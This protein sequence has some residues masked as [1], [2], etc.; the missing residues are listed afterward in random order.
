MAFPFLFLAL[1][2]GAGIAVPSLIPIA[3]T[4]GLLAL[5]FLLIL[6]WLLFFMDRYKLSLVFVLVAVFFLGLSL[7]IHAEGE[8]ETNSLHQLKSDTY[9]DFYGTVYRSPSR[10][11]DSDYL[12]LKIDRAIIQGKIEKLRGKL[13]VTVPH[14]SEFPTYPD[15]IVH[16]KMKVSAKLS[17]STGFQNFAPSPL[18]KN[19]K[20]QNI[21]RRAHTKSPLMVEKLKSG[22][23]LS[24][25]RFIS[26][27]RQRFQKK[28]ERHFSLEDG[29]L[30][31]QG[32][33]LEALMLG[34]RGRMPEAISRS[35]QKAGIF[36]LFAISGAHIAIISF[37]LFSF[38]RLIRIS[39]RMSFALLIAFLLFFALL[40]EG[41]PSVARATIMAMAFLIGK[42]IWRDVNLINTISLSAFFLLMVNPF[43]LATLGFQLTFAA[44]FAIIL[45]YP[46]IIKRLPRLPLRF[47]EVLALSLTAQFGVLPIVAF[48]FNRVTFSALI[49]N[50][51]AIPLVAAIMAIGYLFMPLAMVSGALA[52]PLVF[53]LN[54]LVEILLHSSRLLDFIPLLS[55]RVPTPHLWTAAG[56]YICLLLFLIPWRNKKQR[57]I[58]SLC[59]FAFFLVLV[60]YPFTSR[61]KN[62]RVT[63]I[64]VGQGDSVLIEFPGK[65]KMLVDGGGTQD[66]TFDIGDKVISPFLWRKGIKK[67]DYLVLTHAHPDHMN[68]LK[69]IARNFKIINYWEGFSPEDSDAYVQLRESLSSQVN[70]QN[71]FK[72]D[73]TS[74]G[75]TQIQILHPAKRE[76]VIHKV[77]NN[78]S[79][80]LRIMHGQHSFLL[81]GD[82]EREIEAQILK[83]HTDVDSTVLKSPHHAS[84]SSS[85]SEFLERVSPEIIVISVG[86][87]NWYGLPHP[88]VLE[89]YKHVGAKVFRT[90]IHGAIEITSDKQGISVRTA[91]TPPRHSKNDSQMNPIEN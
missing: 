23:Q 63:F 34:E 36:H 51:A 4:P 44:T 19:L 12:Y 57:L 33:I 90:D 67:I 70:K 59:F 62:L 22:I 47:S 8:Y 50:Y 79:L 29:K 14:S 49:L 1:A 17:P 38:F 3:L 46:R 61:S 40:V 55:F 13:R 84:I 54:F 43:N 42:L 10:G 35:L 88:E 52:K 81:T 2:L 32:A 91:V 89:R 72:G 83:N 80:V 16:D 56:Y 78:Q 53:V 68:G 69:A 9:L 60:I 6:S 41:R 87:G 15:W 66:D 77:H 85:S 86:K 27:I 74:V 18:E 76:P 58:L 11:K 24:P 28:I 39:E 64:D 37:L 48:A 71:M 7:S 30:S 45:F 31:P 26:I 73:K 75:S 82:I 65:T 21:H 5:L 25:L 20:S